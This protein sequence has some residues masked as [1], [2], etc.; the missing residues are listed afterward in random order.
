MRAVPSHDPDAIDRPSG[1]NAQ[2]HTGPL[3]PSYVR[4]CCHVRVSHSL[5]EWSDEAVRRYAPLGENVHA[6]TCWVWPCSARSTA[7]LSADQIR[8]A[9][10]YGDDT[11]LPSGDIAHIAAESPGSNRAPIS[12]PAPASHIRMVPSIPA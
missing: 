6:R 10:R 4:N 2:H 9:E 1:E 5:S 12:P 3:C 8:T 7:P 11:T